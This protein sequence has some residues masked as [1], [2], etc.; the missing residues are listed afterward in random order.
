VLFDIYGPAEDG[1]YWN[2]CRQL[3]KR[4]PANVSVKYWGGVPSDQVASIIDRHDLL[5]L[6]TRGENYGHVIAEALSVGTPVLLSDQTP[7]RNLQADGMGWD[8]PLADSAGFAGA[9][10][11]LAATTQQ[12]KD[13]RRA[14]IRRRIVERLMDPQIDEANRELFR[15]AVRNH[16][17]LER[18]SCAC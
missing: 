1:E 16:K 6:P 12:E 3:M 15:C 13:E 5:F 7:W 18:R 4:L 14:D 2:C 11:G 17:G 9:I 8:I 10:D